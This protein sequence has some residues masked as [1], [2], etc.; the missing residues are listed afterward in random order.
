MT[1][2][3]ELSRALDSKKFN[4]SGGGLN[5]DISLPNNQHKIY[6]SDT[7]GFL[8]IGFFKPG[9][10]NTDEQ[11][12]GLWFYG[13][14]SKTVGNISHATDGAFRLR[15]SKAISDT[16]TTFIDLF[17]DTEGNLKWASNKVECF[18]R[19]GSESSWYK[20]YLDGWIEQGGSL[21]SLNGTINFPVSMINGD[22]TAICV[23][24]GTSAKGE[25]FVHCYNKTTTYMKYGLSY[26]TSGMV[27]MSWYICG[28]WK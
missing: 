13:G 9:A 3:S 7:N 24:N 20:K 15:A 4:V 25:G 6:Q 19:G 10:L 1:V 21:V 28:R 17:G 2:L 18:S 27:G 22:Y 16:D 23:H 5:G 8:R 26:S 11:G 14:T 12:A